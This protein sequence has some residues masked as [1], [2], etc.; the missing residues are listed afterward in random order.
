MNTNSYTPQFLEGTY[1][2]ER[3]KKEKKKKE[4]WGNCFENK[5]CVGGPKV[6]KR[7]R[8]GEMSQAIGKEHPFVR[9]VQRHMKVVEEK[10]FADVSI[11]WRGGK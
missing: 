3:Q 10:R 2:A 1:H 6:Q 8:T 4:F 11:E 9:N 7:R 5:E